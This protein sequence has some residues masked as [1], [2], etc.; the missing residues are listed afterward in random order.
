MKKIFL[1][2][3]AALYLSSCSKCDDQND[4]ICTQ[5]F[6]MVTIKVKSQGDENV[7]LDS[8]YT[9][10]QSTNQKIRPE[11]QAGTDYYV[12]LDD[13]YHP[14][15]KNKEDN[16]RFVGWKNNQVVVDQ[17]Y[18]IGGDNCHISKKSGADSVTL[19]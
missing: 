18:R 1:L 2:V 13:S 17:V 14:Q 7:T 11:Q 10:R 8:A 16:F 6:R 4:F 12:V 15:L 5:E 3:A 9:I 19:Q